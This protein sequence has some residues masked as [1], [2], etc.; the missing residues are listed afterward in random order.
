MNENSLKPIMIGADNHIVWALF[1]ASMLPKLAAY[2]VK[3]SRVTMS[4]CASSAQYTLYTTAFDN[5]LSFG[6]ET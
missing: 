6:N 5:L 1:T 4:V 2:V 3:Q